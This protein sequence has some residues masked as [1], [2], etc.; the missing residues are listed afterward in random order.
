MFSIQYLSVRKDRDEKINFWITGSN[1]FPDIQ[2]L[3][4]LK[5]KWTDPTQ[6]MI[7]PGDK[8]LRYLSQVRL[9]WNVV[10]RKIPLRRKSLR[11][12]VIKSNKTVEYYEEKCK[13]NYVV[14]NRN[15][16]MKCSEHEHLLLFTNQQN[17]WCIWKNMRKDKLRQ[18]CSVMME[19]PKSVRVWYHFLP[20]RRVPPRGIK[21]KEPKMWTARKK[22]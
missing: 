17:A 1:D 18:T 7:D 12:I 15:V 20:H 14:H 5:D 11:I 6:F 21:M 16:C 22:N 8:I 9:I 3:I 2:E 19:S 4:K 10:R 13:H